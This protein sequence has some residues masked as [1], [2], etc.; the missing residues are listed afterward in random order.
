MG[1]GNTLTAILGTCDLG[2][3]L[4]SHITCSGKAVRFLDHCLADHSSVLQHIVQIYQAAVMHMLCKIVC[5]MEMD[6][7]FLMCLYDIRWKQESFCNVLADLACHIVT[8]RGIDHRI[9]IGILLFYF[10]VQMVNQS[11]NPIVSRI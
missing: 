1:Q 2:N 11:Q 8:L 9:F 5:I 4:G 3:R 7:P 10:L 6:Q